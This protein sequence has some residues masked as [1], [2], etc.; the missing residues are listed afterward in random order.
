M[1]YRQKYDPMRV[2]T[3]TVMAAFLATL[4]AQYNFSGEKDITTGSV[5]IAD[6]TSNW[7]KLP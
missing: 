5:R 2:L 3:V 1:K 7:G 4:V 6:A